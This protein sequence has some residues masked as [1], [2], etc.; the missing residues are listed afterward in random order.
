MSWFMVVSLVKLELLMAV[1]RLTVTL[2]SRPPYF[3]PVYLW[4]PAKCGPVLNLYQGV[5]YISQTLLPCIKPG[6]R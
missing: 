6:Q 2:L 4:V 3:L 5:S 1:P